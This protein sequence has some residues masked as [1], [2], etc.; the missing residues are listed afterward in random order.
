MMK[1]RSFRNGADDFEILVCCQ[2]LLAPWGATL[3]PAGTMGIVPVGTV[4]LL[5]LSR[6]QKPPEIKTFMLLGD[7]G[8]VLFEATLADIARFL[9]NHDYARQSRLH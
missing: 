5:G 1:F 3:V 8:V 2:W 6:Q 4:P 7:D 9:K